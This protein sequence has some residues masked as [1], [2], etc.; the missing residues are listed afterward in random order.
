MSDMVRHEAGGMAAVPAGTTATQGFSTQAI[1]RSAETAAS[2]VAAQARAAIE[3]RY[4]VAMRTPRD[5]DQVRL[6]VLKECRRPGFA[7]VARYHKPIGKGVTGPSI[8][9]VEAALRCLGNVDTTAQTIFDSAEKRIVRVTVVDLESNASYSQDVAIDK[10]VER[11]R[12]PDGMTPLSVRT[13]SYGK[14]TYLLPATEDDLLNKQGALVSKAVRTLGLRIVP[15]DIVDEAMAIVVEVQENRDA[16]DPDAARRKLVDAFASVAV[17]PADLKAYLGHDLDAI[18]K[19]EMAHLRALYAAIRDGE[20][21]WAEAF[22][23]RTGGGPEGSKA[24][25]LADRVRARTAPK[26]KEAEAT[27]APPTREPGD[28]S[29]EE[30]KA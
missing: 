18:S 1:E 15:G 20:A 22:E 12:V 5:L 29:D 17:K 14:A 26:A 13:N 28:D 25:S 21:T 30:V 11:S 6:R 4:V 23:K 16:Q 24:A 2:A 7:D 8:R 27:T 10:V 19:S 9:F 3:A